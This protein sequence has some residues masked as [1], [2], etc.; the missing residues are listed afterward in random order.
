MFL[1]ATG[2]QRETLD[3]GRLPR[4]E[5]SYAPSYTDGRGIL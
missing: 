5:Y 3:Y 1:D 4:G 2:L